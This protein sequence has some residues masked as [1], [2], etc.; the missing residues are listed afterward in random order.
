MEEASPKTNSIICQIPEID[1][2][3]PSIMQFIEDTPY[4]NCTGTTYGVLK[5]AT[6]NFKGKSKVLLWKDKSQS[7]LFSFPTTALNDSV[8]SK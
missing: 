7:F 1:P 5:D 8:K 3:H 2:F 4:P 6:L